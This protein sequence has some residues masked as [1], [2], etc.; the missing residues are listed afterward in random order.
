MVSHVGFVGRGWVRGMPG[1]PR[2]CFHFLRF[3]LWLLG[4]FP[5]PPDSTPVYVSCSKLNNVF[6]CSKLLSVFPS[7]S[8]KVDPIDCYLKFLNV[9]F[10]DVVVEWTTFKINGN[11]YGKKIEMVGCHVVNHE[12]IESAF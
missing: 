8:G 4:T 11:K 5:P 1:G 12:C 10:F 3:V 9:T 7:Y 6:V 2:E